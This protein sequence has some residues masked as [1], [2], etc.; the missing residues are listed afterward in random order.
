M[1]EKQTKEE[2]EA[3]LKASTEQ[4]E[5][6]AEEAKKKADDAIGEIPDLEEDPEPSTP[7]PSEEDPEPTPSEPAPSPDYKEKFSQSSRENQKIYAKNRKINE[8]MS[9]ASELNVTDEEVQAEYSDW[10]VMSDTEQRLAKDN[11]INKKRFELVAQ[12]TTEAKKIEKWSD[13]VAEYIQDPKVLAD[14]PQLEGKEKE[15]IE[16][17]N[18]PENHS[19]PMKILTSAFLHD[20]ESKP[21]VKNKGGM[22][23]K[24][25][26]GGIPAKPKGNKITLAQAEV[27]RGTNYNLYKEYLIAGKIDNTIPE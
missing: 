9:K 6:D 15:F 24:G 21:K 1:A 17:A 3:A 25:T 7:A 12:A 8:A 14:I 18:N 19:I 22:F 26:G 23:E 5:K 2:I 27:L 16:F 11:F 4:I 10:D 20:M 13:D